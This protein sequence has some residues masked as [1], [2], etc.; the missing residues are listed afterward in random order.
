MPRTFYNNIKGNNC[1]IVT[2][3]GLNMK[4]NCPY[5]I[6]DGINMKGKRYK[7][8]YFEFKKLVGRQAPLSKLELLGWCKLDVRF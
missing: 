6:L 7:H 5:T 2:E 1:I 3:E 4:P 8:K